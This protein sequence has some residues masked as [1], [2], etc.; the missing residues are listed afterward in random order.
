MAGKYG[1]ASATISYDDAPGGSLRNITAHVLTIGGLKLEEIT[2][3]N[4]P[5]GATAESNT[6]VGKQKIADV[7]IHGNFDTSATTGPH[8][9]FGTPDTDPNG[10][11]RTLT[12]V[13][14]DGKTLTYET[15]LASYE[16]ALTN[17][18]LTGYN[19][20]VRNAQTTRAAWA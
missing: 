9:V 12:I 7:T 15:R 17:G 6:P 19:A 8:V 13:P 5:F 1:S 14:G 2:E 11:T 4:S 3:E 20:V 16:V 18:K 10:A